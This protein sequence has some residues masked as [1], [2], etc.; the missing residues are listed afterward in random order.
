MI[1]DNLRYQV[2]NRCIM[3]NTA[4]DIIFDENGNFNFSNDFKKLNFN[5]EDKKKLDQLIFRIRSA[6]KNKDYN[7]IVGLSGGLIVVMFW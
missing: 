7:C 4:N 5:E 1:R 2:C 6:Q 3:D